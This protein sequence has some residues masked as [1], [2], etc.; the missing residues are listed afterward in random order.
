MTQE[1]VTSV[2]TGGVNYLAAQGVQGYHERTSKRQIQVWGCVLAHEMYIAPEDL[3][4][5]LQ[6]LQTHEVWIHRIVSSVALGLEA[7]ESV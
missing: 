6:H 1:Q 2:D 4:S 3:N 5:C 7:G